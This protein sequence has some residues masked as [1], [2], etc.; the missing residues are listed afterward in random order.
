MREIKGSKQFYFGTDKE[1]KERIYLFK[2]SFD[3][4]WYWGFGYLGNRN[5]HYHLDS[6]SKGRNIDMH[7][8]LTEDYD[9]NPLI[10]K[11]LWVFCELVQ[12]AYWL[13]KAAE[14]LGRGGAHYTNNPCKSVI[15]NKK[16]TD[17]INN[18]VLPAIF[19]ELSN[20]IEKKS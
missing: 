3:C 7:S 13:K 5:C 10:K 4:G 8:A 17:R 6:Y 1:T 2:P 20:L 18:I 11:N 14:V 19:N 15:V 16:E 12:T 9:L